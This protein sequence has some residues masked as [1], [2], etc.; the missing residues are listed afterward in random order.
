MIFAI[1]AEKYKN[2]LKKQLDEY[3][4]LHFVKPDGSLD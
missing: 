4:G 3:Y 1:L 2:L